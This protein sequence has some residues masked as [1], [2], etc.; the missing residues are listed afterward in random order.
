MLQF[1]C[2]THGSIGIIKRIP[3][4]YI[5]HPSVNSPLPCWYSW[6]LSLFT[7]FIFGILRV[8]A[9]FQQEIWKI[10]QTR[11]PGDDLRIRSSN[12]LINTWVKLKALSSCNTPRAPWVRKINDGSKAPL[13]PGKTQFDSVGRRILIVL[14]KKKLKKE[15]LSAR[16]IIHQYCDA[17]CG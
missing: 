5:I 2:P 3:L 10:T 12:R 9:S 4:F 7:G 8:D 14:I 13:S 1:N 17:R 6:M 16:H 15:D 11:G